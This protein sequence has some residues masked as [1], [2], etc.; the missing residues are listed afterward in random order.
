[1]KYIKLPIIV[2]FD[3]SKTSE[4]E[5]FMLTSIGVSTVLLSV[6]L[7]HSRIFATYFN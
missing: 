3:K 4:E 7:T 2:G 6:S 5:Y 1:V